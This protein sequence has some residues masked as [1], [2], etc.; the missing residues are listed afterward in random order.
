MWV[1]FYKLIIMIHYSWFELIFSA[2]ILLGITN[3]LF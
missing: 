2:V 1:F 3:T